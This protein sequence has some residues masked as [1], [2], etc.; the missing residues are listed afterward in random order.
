MPSIL[1][2]STDW[3]WCGQGWDICTQVSRIPFMPSTILQVEHWSIK[4]L[5]S[6]FAP[7]P[8]AQEYCF[9]LY[10][11]QHM[12]TSLNPLNMKKTEMRFVRF[13]MKT[14]D[15][16][17]P[18]GTPPNR[19]FGCPKLGTTS[20]GTR[21]DLRARDWRLRSLCR[22]LPGAYPTTRPAA[23]HRHTYLYSHTC[24]ACL[25]LE[26]VYLTVHLTVRIRPE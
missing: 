8:F 7:H 24:L 15:Y 21:E 3:G 23:D 26:P 17:G 22:C 9:Y 18:L 11:S 2:A 13:W 10:M 1:L 6:I 5:Q 20:W 25:G 14:G 16:W 4:L 19:P 12:F